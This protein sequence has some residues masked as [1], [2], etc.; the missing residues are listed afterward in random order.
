MFVVYKQET[1]QS[2]QLKI[3]IHKLNTNTF[4]S[5][6]HILFRLGLELN[7]IDCKYLSM[8]DLSWFGQDLG[9]YGTRT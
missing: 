9:V 5:C 1:N 3:L 6:T 8:C 4:S 7:E 2:S